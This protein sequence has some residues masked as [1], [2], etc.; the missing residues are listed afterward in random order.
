MA[1]QVHTRSLPPLLMAS[2]SVSS[3]SSLLNLAGVSNHSKETEEDATP[4]FSVK[5]SC[6]WLLLFTSHLYLSGEAWAS[7]AEPGSPW[8]GEVLAWE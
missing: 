4:R 8:E 2:H 6:H 5:A 1:R 3:M 7:W